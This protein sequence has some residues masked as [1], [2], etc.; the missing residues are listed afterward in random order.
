ME[1]QQKRFRIIVALALIGMLIINGGLGL[2]LMSWRD[3][4]LHQDEVITQQSKAILLAAAEIN[5][6][7]V[8][9]TYG[10][11]YAFIA[12]L[13]LDFLIFDGPVFETLPT[14][15]SDQLAICGDFYYRAITGG[16]TP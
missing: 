16:I 10:S 14:L 8:Q 1:D 15:N 4:S 2:A 5:N 3:Y 7:E 6:L 9:A 13:R 12:N 11:C